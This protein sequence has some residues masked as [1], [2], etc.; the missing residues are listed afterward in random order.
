MILVLFLIVFIGILEINV[1]VILNSTGNATLINENITMGAVNIDEY[2]VQTKF[3]EIKDIPYNEHSMNCKNKS[4]MFAE[5]LIMMGGTDVYLVTIPHSSGRYSHEF[6]E[7][8]GHYYNPCYVGLS[9]QVS[10][11]DYLNNLHRKGFNGLIIQSPYVH[12]HN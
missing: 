7:W 3:K 2:E 8:N 12:N 11:E 6:V 5:Y 1:G 9:Y 10:K 4:E